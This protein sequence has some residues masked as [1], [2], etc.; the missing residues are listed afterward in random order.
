MTERQATVVDFSKVV[1][2]AEKAKAILG[3]LKA[4]V[5]EDDDGGASLSL[6][7]GH[8]WAFDDLEEALRLRDQINDALKPI[9]TIV[10]QRSEEAL[11]RLATGPSGRPK[12]EPDVI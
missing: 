2:E 4:M 7:G 3:G 5:D 10:R 12:E 1:K 9:C 11:W 6:N 8:V